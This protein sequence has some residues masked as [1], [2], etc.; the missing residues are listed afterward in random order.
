MSTSRRNRRVAQTAALT[1]GALAV[2]A[3][4]APAALAM[5]NPDATGAVTPEAA[6]AATPRVLTPAP[7]LRLGSVS[8]P[9]DFGLGKATISIAAEAGS[10]Y[11]A[12][13]ALDL[14]G[15]TVQVTATGSVDADNSFLSGIGG[16]GT[17]ATCITVAD[18]SCLFPATAGGTEN[19][20]NESEWALLPGVTYTITQL[21]APPSGQL[22]LPSE[23]DRT[24]YAA[25]GPLGMFAQLPPAVAEA[26]VADVR[27]GTGTGTGTVIVDPE[28]GAVTTTPSGVDRTSADVHELAPAT[29]D[30]ESDPGAS[31]TFFDPGAYRTV[32]ATVTDDRGNP[33]PG[34]TLALCTVA[35]QDCADGT[36]TVSATSAGNGVA[37]FPGSYLPGTYRATV[38]AAP[39]GYQLSAASFPITVGTATTAADAATP[40]SLAVSL[41]PTEGPAPATSAAAAPTTPTASGD[42]LASTGFAAGPVA[43][44]AGGLVATGAAALL[45]ARRRRAS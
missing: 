3:V 9:V 39:S 25:V 29:T 2:G 41:T 12:G 7:V 31:I 43:A 1:M 34:A 33:V 24:V 32:T 18:G 37:S 15:A 13:V 19:L 16:A 42:Q 28:T 45:A 6:D 10:S 17:S 27:S 5:Q 22:L 14:S 35:G 8:E 23:T 4:T 20:A 40:V 44:V 21:T 38:T 11:P 36:R 26:A 30:V